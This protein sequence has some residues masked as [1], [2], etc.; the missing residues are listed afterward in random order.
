MKT[1]REDLALQSPESKPRWAKWLGWDLSTQIVRLAGALKSSCL[2]E[3][4]RRESS[5]Q[6]FI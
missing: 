5:L 1:L 6:H 3:N 2:N 4:T